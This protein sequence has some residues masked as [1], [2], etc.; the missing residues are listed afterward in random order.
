MHLTLWEGFSTAR[1]EKK[2]QNWVRPN[3]G[4]SFS[5]SFSLDNGIILDP[6]FFIIGNWSCTPFNV[7]EHKG[8]QAHYSTWNAEA[9]DEVH[10]TGRHFLALEL[11]CGKYE[12][13]PFDTQVFS[14]FADWFQFF[15]IL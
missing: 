11:H 14:S 6:I 12:D 2:Q 8:T 13:I 5:S 1:N 9:L 7:A 4:C 10:I 15:L 3:K